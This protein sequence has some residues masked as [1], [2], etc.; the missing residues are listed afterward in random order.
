MSFA[1]RE[2][3]VVQLGAALGGRPEVLEAYLFGSTARGE[4]RP[5]SFAARFRAIAGFRNVL[6]HG[7][8]EVDLAI[9]QE[10]L[11]SRLDDFREFARY[12]DTHLES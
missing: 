5:H 11:T 2:A 3:L 8:L 10:M 9:V 12:V 7:Y 4:S 6:V 1:E